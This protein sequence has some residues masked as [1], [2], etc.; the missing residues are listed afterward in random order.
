MEEFAP[1]PTGKPPEGIVLTGKLIP[2]LESDQPAL[3]QMPACQD[4]FLPVF[5][6]EDALRSVMGQAGIPFFKI[7]QIDDGREFLEE[8]PY[9]YSGARLRIAVDLRFTEEGRVRFVEVFRNPP[10]TE[11]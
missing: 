1:R 4:Y 6:T 8:L 10:T 9:W 7:K 5:S 11:E 2:W 3:V